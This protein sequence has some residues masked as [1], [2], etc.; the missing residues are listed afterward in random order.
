MICVIPA[1]K[2]SGMQD[3]KGKRVTVFGLGRFGGGIHVS[4]WLC[5]QGAHVLVTDK[6]PAD[7]LADSVKQLDGLP[8]QFRLGEHRKEDFTSTDLLVISPAIAPSNE[9]LI[10]AQRAS[11]PVTLEIRLFIERCPATIIGGDATK[12]KSTTT[13]M[14]GAMLRQKHTTHVG[15]NLGD[16]CCRICRRSRA[17][18]LV[19]L[20]LSSYM[21][22][23][24]APLQWSPHVAV[25]G[26]I[27]RDHLEWHGGEESY[28][29]AKQNLVRFQ[30]PA[31]HA[32][33]MEDC[34][35]ACGFADHTRSRVVRFNANSS[36]RFYPANCRQ[37]QSVKC[38]RRLHRREK[39]FGIHLGRCA[40]SDGDVQ[41]SAPPAPT[42]PREQWHPMDQ[43]FHRHH[44]PK[45]AVVARQSYPRGKV[46]QI[47]GGY[48]K[49]LEMRPMCQTLARECKAILT[50]G[51][52]GPTLAAMIR[53]TPN[54][55]AG[56][57]RM[58]QP[59]PRRR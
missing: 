44:F 50:I 22:E 38:P 51:D 1:D 48:D 11:V 40:E 43:R 35:G 41:P 10:A 13:A 39:S 7:K 18:D 49:K 53:H 8:I 27:G 24:L 2:I 47:I 15:G 14:L 45:A 52:L 56:T 16:H 30:K 26:M 46:I 36:D 29:N 33:L 3:F 57:Y 9:Y 12:G 54:R 34:P 25:V 20:E 55:S 17:G 4:R 37:S 23:H 58:Q 28:V 5:Q 32:I 59:P 31:D 21:L 6:D 42:R 19:V